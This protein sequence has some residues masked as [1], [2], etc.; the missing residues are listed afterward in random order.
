[1]GGTGSAK[2]KGKISSIA[3]KE[4]GGGGPG[5]LGGDAGKG[6]AGKKK[7]APCGREMKEI[8]YRKFNLDT[9]KN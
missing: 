4:T 2:L 8:L 9:K 3:K 5:A 6:N 7:G 1:V